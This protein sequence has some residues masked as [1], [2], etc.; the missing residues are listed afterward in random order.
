MGM[1]AVVYA[2]ITK[3]PTGPDLNDAKARYVAQLSD[4]LVSYLR[5]D[6]PFSIR[7]LYIDPYNSI[8]TDGFIARAAVVSRHYSIGHR[9]GYWPWIRQTIEGL[10]AAFPDSSIHYMSDA[11]DPASWILP[12]TQ[13]EI[14]ALQQDWDENGGEDC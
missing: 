7:P 11:T 6:D 14:D 12:L 4:E 5:G 10:R 8:K 1:D 3:P 13:D 9:R 2:R